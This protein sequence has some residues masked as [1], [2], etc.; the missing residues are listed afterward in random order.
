MTRENAALAL[1]QKTGK[2]L[3]L[4]VS[5]LP[6]AGLLLGIGSAHF[7]WLPPL[8][9]D[10]MTGVSLAGLPESMRTVSSTQLVQRPPSGP[11][12]AFTRAR[13]RKR[14][15]PSPVIVALLEAALTTTGAPQSTLYSNASTSVPTSGILTEP[16]GAPFCQS[17]LDTTVWSC[18]AGAYGPGSTSQPVEAAEAWEGA[19]TSA[20]KRV[21]RNMRIRGLTTPVI[22]SA[23]RSCSV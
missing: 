10:V 14:N 21:R 6:V 13:C 3:M 8:V 22:G 12:S 20:V 1:L 18:D 23:P 2:S 7:T 4:P 16:R 11:A 5:V 15:S 9:S 19:M 17:V